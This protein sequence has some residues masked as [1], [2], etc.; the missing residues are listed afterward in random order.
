MPETA[1]AKEEVRC[2]SIKS[3][4]QDNQPILLACGQVQVHGS[5]PYSTLIQPSLYSA[6]YSVDPSAF[7]HSRERQG[8]AVRFTG[9]RVNWPG[10]MR[11]VVSTLPFTLYRAERGVLVVVSLIKGLVNLFIAIL[12]INRERGGIWQRFQ[13]HFARERKKDG[14]YQYEFG[15]LLCY[16]PLK[17]SSALIVASQ[18]HP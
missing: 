13:F 3:F 7:H 16:V 10:R 4:V 9:H 17:G 15:G 12:L 8:R 11:A 14:V 18:C 6:Q 2:W 1:K 5:L